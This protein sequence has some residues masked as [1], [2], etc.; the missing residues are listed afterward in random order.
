[1]RGALGAAEDCTIVLDAMADHFTAAMRT[2]RSECGAHVHPAL[3]FASLLRCRCL[4]RY[5]DLRRV[6]EF[7]AA[8]GAGI[9]G[10]NP[11]HILSSVA[12]QHASPYNPSSRLFGN[13]IYIDVQA[14][15]ECR[16]R[17]VVAPRLG[18]PRD[19]GGDPLG[20]VGDGELE[21]LKRRQLIPPG[22][23]LAVGGIVAE[24]GRQ[25]RR[26]DA[27]QRRSP[28]KKTSSTASV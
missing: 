13:P 7:A 6:T 19:G 16:G 1:M 5:I 17:S 24:D 2:N 18:G 9:V 28:P 10:L 23:G 11:L 12:P 8:A 21:A 26:F 15:P 22:L 27:D 4:V 25:A 3:T 20:G 14:V